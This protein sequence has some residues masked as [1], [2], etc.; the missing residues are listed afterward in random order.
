M[1]NEENIQ[2]SRLRLEFSARYRG[3]FC[4]WE[5]KT[6]IYPCR[7]TQNFA[8]LP[9]A[10]HR[11]NLSPKDV[12]LLLDAV[13]RGVELG[14]IPLPAHKGRRKIWEH[15]EDSKLTAEQEA[16]FES[17]RKW[18]VKRAADRGV[19]VARI[20]TTSLLML[21]AGAQPKTPRELAAVKGMEPWRQREYGDELLA[22]V[23][24]KKTS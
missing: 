22:V 24:E 13:Q 15:K 17:L 20:A 11:R 12:Q 9:S 5:S 8:I 21:I 1:C 16:L 19:D 14:E 2:P 6:A 18:R 4:N 10:N 3:R 23:C 7:V